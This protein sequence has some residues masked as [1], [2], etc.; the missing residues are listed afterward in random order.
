MILNRP[1]LVLAAVAA[2]C[3]RNSSFNP[4]GWF[5][6]PSYSANPLLH[7]KAKPRMS[8]Y[9][10]TEEQGSLVIDAAISYEVGSP[11]TPSCATGVSQGQELPLKVDIFSDGLL[12]DTAVISVGSTDNEI[13]LRLDGLSAS[14]EPYNITVKAEL[15]DGTTYTTSTNVYRLPYPD[16]YGTVSRVDNLYGG[17][18]Y[19]RGK[20]SSWQSIF[21]YTYYV[22]WTL[23]WQDNVT[24]LDEFAS[25]GYNLIHIVPTGS[26]GESPFP[27]DQ[28]QPYL[29][30]AA[31]LGI[32]FQYDVMWTATNDTTMLEQITQLRSHPSI[33]L[34]YQSDEPD[35][36]GHALNST[37]LARDK[38]RELDP[39]HPSSLALNCYD[40]YYPDY[41][42]G[43]EIIISDVYPIGNNVTWSSE[44]NTACNATY[45]CC[46]CDDCNGT[47]EDISVR[48][49]EFVHRDNILGWDKVHWSAPQAFGDSQ[50]W[51]RYPTAAEE[52]VMALIAVNHGAKGLVA[53]DFPTTAELSAITQK[54]A[55]VLTTASIGEF[56]LETPLTK[57]LAVEGGSRVD[58]AVWVNHQKK[59]ALLSVINLN[60]SDLKGSIK[61]RLPEGLKAKAVYQNLWGDASWQIEGQNT[62][63]STGGLLG[64]Q[65]S[66]VVLSL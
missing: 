33:L 35:G 3:T 66:L 5:D 1:Y 22:Q 28:F 48:I 56:L 17:L 13:P 55:G 9:L 34:W 7:L 52:V 32:F 50:F 45:G 10:D 39:Y 54:L 26:L 15:S 21:P 40:F 30:R 61:V 38:M 31:E 29:D 53:W 42:Q 59:Q 37:G 43:G 24:T 58:A 57:Q 65:A 23:Y 60:Y 4:G 63:I 62:L 6:Y 18:W 20:E 19:Q 8:I 47:F 16:N 12:L 51:K 46:G 11:I 27:W 2:W 64:L 14:L 25:M 36:Q 49:D 44:Y 41:A